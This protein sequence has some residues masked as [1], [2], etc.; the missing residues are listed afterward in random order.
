[1][2]QQWMTMLLSKGIEIEQNL[3]KNIK[4]V[5][6]EFKKKLDDRGIKLAPADLA[7]LV[8]ELSP[9]IS[10][11]ALG[12]ALDFLRPFSAGMGFRVSKLSDTKIELVLP[13]RSRNLNEN[14][15]IHE[16][17]LIAGCI[18][19]A[20]LMLARHEPPGSV[21][22]KINHLQMS[23]TAPV[24]SEARIRLEFAELQREKLLSELRQ[25]RSSEIE[26]VAQILNTSEINVGE[27]HIRMH[28]SV[29]EALSSTQGE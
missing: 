26:L 29:I 25:N 4:Q 9:E 23:L 24:Q 7:A 8:E 16:A 1:M 5:Q 15:E 3:R 21:A 10:K 12:Y 18:E 19:S 13:N 27:V 11:N 22:Y 17:A 20:K 2:N 28:I 6:E 14:S